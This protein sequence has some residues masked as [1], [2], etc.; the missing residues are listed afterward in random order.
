MAADEGVPARAA[1]ARETSDGAYVFLATVV[2]RPR[3]R[4][5]AE[6]ARLLARLRSE[7]NACLMGGAQSPAARQAL[8]R[9]D[10][11]SAVEAGFGWREGHAAGLEGPPTP[12]CYNV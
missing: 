9:G 10:A 8:P 7:I 5:C 6:L 1:G 3:E 11:G 2:A 4:L 12:Y